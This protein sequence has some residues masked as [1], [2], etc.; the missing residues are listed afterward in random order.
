MGTMLYVAEL[1]W[2]GGVGVEGEYQKATNRMGMSTLGV[3][4]S[5]RLGIVAAESGL[6][7]A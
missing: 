7:P 6:T 4:R 5:T 1:T 2:N 3:F